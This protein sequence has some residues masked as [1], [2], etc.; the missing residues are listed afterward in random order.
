MCWISVQTI[1]SN[2]VVISSGY[3]IGS[4]GNFDQYLLPLAEKLGAAISASRAALDAG[5]AS[6]SWQVGQTGKVIAPNLY[7]ARGE[8]ADSNAQLVRRAVDILAS[9]GAS[10]ASATQARTLLGL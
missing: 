5:Y 10:P 9:L 1:K 2:K 6:N 3:A 4:K 7:I 8:L